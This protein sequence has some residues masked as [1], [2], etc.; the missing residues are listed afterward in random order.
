M[1][2]N[3]RNAILCNATKIPS[4][5][6]ASRFPFALVT[7]SFMHLFIPYSKS[8]TPP[9]NQPYIH[10]HFLLKLTE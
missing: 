5:L 9:T 3:R 10:S 2:D 7:H 1:L 8:E 6:L 4:A